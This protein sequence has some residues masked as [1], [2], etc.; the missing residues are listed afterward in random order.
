MKEIDIEKAKI[1]LSNSVVDI[2]NKYKIPF[3]VTELI[4]GDML[5]QIVAFKNLEI[6]KEQSDDKEDEENVQDTK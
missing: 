4:L 3:G 5:R 6:Q 1:E 2:V